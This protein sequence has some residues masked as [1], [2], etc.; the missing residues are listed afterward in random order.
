MTFNVSMRHDLGNW[1]LHGRRRRIRARVFPCLIQ[2]PDLGSGQFRG[3]GGARFT[4]KAALL[5]CLSIRMISTNPTAGR[6][7]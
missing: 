1:S 4:N 2:T 3:F 6:A 7:P 5:L